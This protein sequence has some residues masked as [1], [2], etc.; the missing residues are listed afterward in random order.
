[1]KQS[2][3]NIHGKKRIASKAYMSETHGRV[4]DC[5]RNR[6]NC[7]QEVADIISTLKSM[8]ATKKLRKEKILYRGLGRNATPLLSEPKFEDHGFVSTSPDFEVASRFGYDVMR[9]HLLPSRTYKILEMENKKEE[10]VLLYPGGTFYNMTTERNST[11]EVIDGVRIFD[12]V[13]IDHDDVHPYN[14][15][16]TKT[17]PR[18]FE[19]LVNFIR[20]EIEIIK[21]LD[22]DYSL[23]R[24]SLH[25]MCDMFEKYSTISISKQDKNEV[26]S[27]FGLDLKA[28]GGRNKAK[29]L[30]KTL[31]T[32][33]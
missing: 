18:T 6:R 14:A 15:S 27:V 28:K 21:E 7:D 1:M 32:I 25:D 8:F 31:K 19:K 29:L 30:K 17:S 26:E 4:N 12:F 9:I 16:S 10:E 20:S 11:I 23:D 2:P 24:A 3:I 5:L 22:E 13:F 33:P